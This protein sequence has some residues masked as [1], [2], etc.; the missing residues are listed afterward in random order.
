MRAIIQSAQ[1]EYQIAQA[2]E[3]DLNCR[4]EESKTQNE[5]INVLLIRLKELAWS[6]P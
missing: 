6:A 4:L 1:S 3:K 2:N 5:K